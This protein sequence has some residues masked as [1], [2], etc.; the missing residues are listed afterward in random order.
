MQLLGTRTVLR[1]NHSTSI[2]PFPDFTNHALYVAMWM[3]LKSLLSSLR[4]SGGSASTYR[5]SSLV[6]LVAF[7]WTFSCSALAESI[8]CR[9]GLYNSI[10]I[11]S[12]LASFPF[13]IILSALY[14][15]VGIVS[16]LL[17][18]S[19]LVSPQNCLF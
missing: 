8:K 2:F 10:V 9:V 17:L 15:S 13:Q 4:L 11:V 5:V 3:S 6:I 1:R 12:V 14:T 19:E 7:H 18:M 16:F